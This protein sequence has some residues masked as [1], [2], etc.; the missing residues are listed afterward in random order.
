MA[1]GNWNSQS[2]TLPGAYVDVYS[3]K[4]ATLSSENLRGVVFTSV[5]GLNWG[6]RGV[7]KAD[8]STD[9]LALFGKSIDDQA[10]LGLKM[11]LQNARTAY[12]FNLNSGT[13]ATGTS[14]VLPWSFAAKY[15]GT[16]GNTISVAITPDPSN[17]ARFIVKTI[18][19]TEVVASQTVGKA[20][21]LVANGYVVPT[22]NA[23]DT[24]DDGA[25]KL[26]ALVTGV[27]VK[28]ENGTTDASS[29]LDDFVVAAETYEYNTIAAPMSA[30]D[31]SIQ[32][33]IA[34]TAIRLR[35]EQG[36][37]V[38]AVVP[39]SSS[40][41]PNHEGVIVVGN[42]VKLADGTVYNTSIMAGW[43]AGATAS[44]APNESLTY[45]RVFGAVDTVPRLNES[46]Q[47]AAVQSGQLVFDASRNLVRVLVDINSL[48]QFTK[49]KGNEFSKNRVL[50]VLDAIANN[51]R[52]TWEDNFIG[53]V[54]N[55]AAGRD[56]FKA[57]RAEYL[58][59]LQ[60]QGAIE[61]FTT[62][63][64]VVSEGNTKDSVVATIN[65]QPTDAMEK[66]YMTVYVK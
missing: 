2:K 63:D 46:A 45:K 1:G 8:L 13:A 24:T 32:T 17:L 27:T 54:T 53:Q 44:A 21:E 19:G 4:S 25:A 57:N 33:L 56:L 42:G 49:T 6:Q 43:F 39:Y 16:L 10:L 30:A 22:V 65:V 31:A 29:S 12:V 60:A 11:I 14:N 40:F 18:L 55:D 48:T 47:I 36:R 59:G 7:V 20:S 50:R 9:F 23:G 52:E 26:G 5:S 58:A 51:T 35:D 66:L 64:I 38:Q 62:D 61:N 37:K 3:S 15:P 28:L 41:S 34:S